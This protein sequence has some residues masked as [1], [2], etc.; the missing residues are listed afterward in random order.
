MNFTNRAF[1]SGATNILCKYAHRKYGQLNYD[2]PAA[3]CICVC[4]WVSAF[5][6]VYTVTAQAHS[7]CS[8]PRTY[9][10]AHTK[11]EEQIALP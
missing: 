9:T 4:E 6:C 8:P 11:C 10:K 7:R 5:P 1:W 3:K 2:Y